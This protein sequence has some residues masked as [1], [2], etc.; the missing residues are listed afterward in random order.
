[1]KIKKLISKFLFILLITITSCQ[2]DFIDSGDA[3]QTEI[4]PDTFS[5]YFGNEISRDF[6]G[7]VVD[8]NSNPIVGVIITIGDQT[9][10]TD[11][12]GVFIINDATINERFGY[13]KAEKA[14]YIHASRSVVPSNGTN[15]VTIMMLEETVAGSVNSGSSSTITTADGSSVSFD[16]NFIKE[17]GT[18]YSGSVDV[19]VHHLDPTDDDMELQMPGMLYAQNEDGEERMLQT[20]GMLDVEL[21]GSGGEDLNLAE[22][23]TS[24]IRMPVD[25]SLLNIAPAT[26]PLWYFDEAKGYWI[27]EGEATLQGNM[28][29][30]TV[31]HFSFWNC[32]IPARAINLCVTVTTEDGIPFANA[33]VTITS[34]T[35]GTR[36]GLTN[37]LGEVCGLVP[38]EESLELNVYDPN[39]CDANSLLTQSIGPY[40]TDSAITVIVPDNTYLV[41]ETITGVLNTCDGDAVTNGYVELTYEGQTL[42]INVTNGSFEFQLMRCSTNDNNAFTLTATDFTNLQT[43]ESLEYNLTSPTTNIGEIN[44]CLDQDGYI[45]YV[46]DDSITVFYTDFI[47]VILGEERFVIYQVTNGYFLADFPAQVG[48][49]TV[50]TNNTNN[51]EFEVPGSGS[52]TTG[53]ENITINVTYVGTGVGD[54]INL[55]FSGTFTNLG[56]TSTINGDAHVRIDL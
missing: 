2:R 16:G 50:S 44:T 29:V 3:S 54:F 26:I 13:V 14:G 11:T 27:E 49:Y 21:R 19:I 51:L 52:I 47:D 20:L 40:T 8:T 24:E 53:Q 33:E 56:T 35:Y 17:D 9:T 25:P 23:S 5:H 28:Y 46:I 43:T 42:L 37:N 41:Q 10:T 38:S 6:I 1:M 45:Q 55:N 12:N 34:I 7:N 22:G 39:V 48:S 36:S 30:G 32:D 15:K 31:S 18:A 4:I